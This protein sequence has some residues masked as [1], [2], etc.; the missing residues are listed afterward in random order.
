MATIRCFAPVF[1]AVLEDVNPSFTS[2]RTAIFVVVFVNKGEVEVQIHTSVSLHA[3]WLLVLITYMY[4]L[5]ATFL[6]YP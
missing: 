2:R 5:R 4:L 3:W 6:A 1:A